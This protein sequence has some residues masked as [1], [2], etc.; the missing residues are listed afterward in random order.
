MPDSSNPNRSNTQDSSWNGE[1]SGVLGGGSAYAIGA[2]LTTQQAVFSARTKALLLVRKPLD[3]AQR[4]MSAS[5]ASTDPAFTESLTALRALA[6]TRDA[7]Y[8]TTSKMEKVASAATMTGTVAALE[9]KAQTAKALLNYASLEVM[10]NPS[11]I[12]F[13]SVAGGS[14]TQLQ[15]PG[16]GG[17]RQTM[18]Y[19]RPSSTTMRVQLIFDRVNQFNAFSLYNQGLSLGSAVGVVS[20]L[21]TDHTVL[22]YVDGI[23]GLMSTDITRHVMFIWSEMT[24]HGR[25]E[26]VDANFTMFNKKGEPIRATV[27]INI[28]ESDSMHLTT[29]EDTYWN[30]AFT[31]AFGEADGLVSTTTGTMTGTSNFF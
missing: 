20:N 9:G 18:Q 6:K 19:T 12:Q 1:G 15:G 29:A 28:K 13:N 7:S 25:L 26:G 14:Y 30:D 23:L 16:D 24:F 3:E 17:A 11:S 21:A 5:T 2:A 8:L 10:Y 27:D 31:K 4:R 22:P